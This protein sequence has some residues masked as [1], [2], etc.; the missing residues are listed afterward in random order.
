MPEDN[1]FIGDLHDDL[2]DLKYLLPAVGVNIFLVGGSGSIPL[3]S[4]PDWLIEEIQRCV[5]EGWKVNE[6]KN[7]VSPGDDEFIAKKTSAKIGDRYVVI[8]FPVWGSVIQ[9][10][11][12]VKELEQQLAWAREEIDSYVRSLA[13]DLK[14]PLRAIISFTEVVK[15]DAA[16]NLTEDNLKS[17]DI[18]QAN[19]NKMEDLYN[20]LVQL[21]KVISPDLKI[22][23]VNLSQQIIEFI[24]S[25]PSKPFRETQIIVKQPLPTIEGDL[26]KLRIAF[27]E[28]VLNAY[29]FNKNPRPRVEFSWTDMGDYIRIYIKDNGIGI[30]PES[31]KQVF[32]VFQK[33][34]P[35]SEGFGIGL[36]RTKRIIEL[37]KGSISIVRSSAEQ[38]T[39]FAIILPKRLKPKKE[40]NEVII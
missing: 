15:E 6:S 22:T 3:T 32:W 30:P 16:D 27:M 33:L 4:S 36:Y 25:Q 5:D 8:V 26:E 39:T 14:T 29:K 40:E 38:G 12:K 24:R 9:L 20:A 31:W 13:H 7:I 19:A 18:I 21:S 23:T 17:L 35:N 2:T 1:E 10:Q 37:H 34:D 28:L 11:H